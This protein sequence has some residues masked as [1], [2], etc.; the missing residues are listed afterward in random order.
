[1]IFIL[2]V[3][4][5]LCT[6]FALPGSKKRDQKQQRTDAF[7]G[8]SGVHV[9]ID[10]AERMCTTVCGCFEDNITHLTDGKLGIN[11]L[12]LFLL[13]FFNQVA[14]MSGHFELGEIIKNHR[15]TDVGKKG[16]SI[17]M[18]IFYIFVLKSLRS[19]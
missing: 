17:F 13:F 9:W 10:W 1:M 2:L 4:G 6:N 5:K 15:D 19:T 16:N 11:V 14:V 3:E 8:D 18:L 7:S 12:W